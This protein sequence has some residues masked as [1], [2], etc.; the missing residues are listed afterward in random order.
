[1][2]V[3]FI[4]ELYKFDRWANEKMLMVVSQLDPDRFT[5]EMGSS[6]SSVRDTL[7]HLVGGEWIWLERWMGRS[8]HALPTPAELPTLADISAKFAQVH[9]DRDRFLQKLDAPKLNAPLSYVNQRGQTWTYPLW[10]MMVHVVNHSTYHRGQITT[11]L[12]QLGARPLM[13]DFLFY[14]DENNL[15]HMTAPAPRPAQ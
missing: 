10:Q 4:A 8:P 1:M 3:A 7:V 15:S 6:F 11:L 12:R 14:Y 2:D 9:A 13:T 5:Q